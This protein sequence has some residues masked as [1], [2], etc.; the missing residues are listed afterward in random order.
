MSRLRGFFPDYQLPTVYDLSPG[1]VK[2]QGFQGLIL[3]IDNTLV[4]PNAPADERACAFAEEMREAG[5][6][7][8]V[9]SNNSRNRAA[10]FAEKLGCSYIAEAKKP[11]PQGFLKG[12]KLLGMDPSALLAVGDQLL[13]DVYGAHRAGMKC[14]LVDALDPAHEQPFV[15]V[16]RILE[17]PVLRA[18]RKSRSQSSGK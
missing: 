8:L 9:L 4:S 10:S 5:I 15:R 1:W 17:K 16:K 13:T 11:R 12:A 7:L 2:A 18:Y 6:S 14:L 3:D